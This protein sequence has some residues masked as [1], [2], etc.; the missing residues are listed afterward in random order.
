MML[1]SCWEIVDD[2]RGHFKWIAP[3]AQEENDRGT[4]F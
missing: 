4:I 2:E 1:D 3:A